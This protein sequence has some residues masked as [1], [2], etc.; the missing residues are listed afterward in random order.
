MSIP[1]AA[2]SVHM[3]NLTSPVCS[4]KKIYISLNNGDQ[5]GKERERERERARKSQNTLKAFKLSFLSCGRRSPWRQTHEYS[6][7]ILL[8][9]KIIIIIII[10]IIIK[11]SLHLL[12]M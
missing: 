6:F 9:P 2:T 5:L 4:E 8:E 12:M 7:T 3:R 1:L 11:I 10:I